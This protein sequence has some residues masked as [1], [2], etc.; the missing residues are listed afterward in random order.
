MPDLLY[1]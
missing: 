1:T